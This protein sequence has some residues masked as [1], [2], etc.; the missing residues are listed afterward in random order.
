MPPYWAYLGR[1]RYIDL[2]PGPFR[3]RPFLVNGFKIWKKTVMDD[4]PMESV[5]VT[6]RTYLA[7]PKEDDYELPKLICC[8]SSAQETLERISTSLVYH[9]QANMMQSQLLMIIVIHFTLHKNLPL[10]IVTEINA[11]WFLTH[12][13]K[14]SQSMFCTYLFG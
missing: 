5:R 7:R 10:Y 9:N 14:L 1:L 2:R 11:M 4:D 12:T 8:E 13:Y 3:I 6:Q